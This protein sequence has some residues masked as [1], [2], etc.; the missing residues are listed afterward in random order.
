MAI[1]HNSQALFCIDNGIGN[2]IENLYYASSFKDGRYDVYGLTEASI[3]TMSNRGG[4]QI[5]DL[6]ICL[7]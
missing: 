6:D 2:N 4:G 5:F 1:S 7:I 3:G